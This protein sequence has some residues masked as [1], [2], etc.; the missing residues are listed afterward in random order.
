MKLFYCCT[1]TAVLVLRYFRTLIPTCTI[2]DHFKITAP[3]YPVSIM[4][5]DNAKL[6]KFIIIFIDRHL[7]I[8][9][10]TIFRIS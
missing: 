4:L 2:M 10:W 8:L 6:Q 3:E 5:H 9:S 7:E 1:C